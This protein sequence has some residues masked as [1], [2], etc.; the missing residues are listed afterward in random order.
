MINAL[1]A[2]L[3]R[4][5]DDLERVE[6]RCTARVKKLAEAFAKMAG[7]YD[8]HETP[9]GLATSTAW[10]RQET[11]RMADDDWE[12]DGLRRHIRDLQTLV[13][14]AAQRAPGV[15]PE[16]MDAARE[17]AKKL[18]WHRRML[19]RTPALK[20]NAAVIAGHNGAADA[21]LE[22]L[23]ALGFDNVEQ[24]LQEQK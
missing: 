13:Q 4:N 23:K 5:Q 12:L 16:C 3:R 19:S 24:F 9:A 17:I 10:V 2:M 14:L 15:P 11:A 22:A 20:K 21:L 1:M 8:R 18:N 7:E 6:K